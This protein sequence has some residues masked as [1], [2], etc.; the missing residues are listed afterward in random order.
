M[1]PTP[2]SPR[3]R[4]VARNV[5]VGAVALTAGVALP[6]MALDRGGDDAVEAGSAT[7]APEIT[8]TTST[9]TTLDPAVAEFYRQQSVNASLEFM[10]T[11]TP[12][13]LFE[14]ESSTWTD[15]E[16]AEFLAF[17]EQ[18]QLNQFYAEQAFFEGVRQAEAARQEAQ[19]AEAARQE[20]ARRTAA[21]AA[22]PTRA[23]G[24]VWDRLAQCEAG[25]NW[26]Y[27]TVSG[28]FSGGLMFHY[29]T[30]NAFG[31]RAYAPSA[32]QASRSQQIAIAE[33]VLASQ[34]WGAWPGC[35]RKLGLR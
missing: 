35:S 2:S 4:R 21:T 29:A 11:L 8:S 17:A 34:G 14:L 12:E 3:Q 31:G 33:K 19:R 15:Q 1:T 9:S 10:A 28:G 23:S 24:S 32:H 16:R 26:A 7:E 13:Q 6:A 18:Q 30:W 22:A 27:P 25:G 20:Q 5:A